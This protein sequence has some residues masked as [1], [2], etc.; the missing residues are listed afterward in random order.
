MSELS[1]RLR[2]LFITGTDTGVGKTLVGTHIVRSWHGAGRSVGAYKPVASGAER[3]TQWTLI[4]SDVEG[5]FTA[6]NGAYPRE[7]ICPQHFTAPLAPPVAARFENR[8]VDSDLLANGVNWWLK[9]VDLL[10]VEGAGGLL[11][12]MTENQSNADLAQLLGLDLL[13]VARAGLGTINHTLL[14]VEAAE[15]RGLSIKGIVL[16]ATHPMSDDQS[17]NSNAEE[18]ARRCSV[19]ILGVLPHSTGGDLLHHPAFLRMIDQL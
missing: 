9:Q 3:D 4:W 16:N 6:L 14:T 5:Y 15:R 11:S 2:G 17:V 19:P 12:P 10:I 7:R 1:Q 13:I 8:I 18:I